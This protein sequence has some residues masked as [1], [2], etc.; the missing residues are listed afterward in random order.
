MP[1]QHIVVLNR[2]VDATSRG[3]AN[4]VEAH[5]NKHTT[6]TKNTITAQ[7]SHLRAAPTRCPRCTSFPP[8]PPTS[9]RY[10]PPT[11]LQKIPNRLLLCISF[12]SS[13]HTSNSIP[14]P[15]PLFIVYSPTLP[16]T[17]LP[18]TS[19]PYTSLHYNT[20]Y[21]ILLTTYCYY[22]LLLLTYS[23]Y[24]ILLATTCCYVLLL[25]IT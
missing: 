8:T 13:P 17:T 9:S 1:D 16:Y 6:P 21:L 25:T 15:P 18:Y 12:S 5:H 3:F 20:S 19:V 22:L 4:C 7:I 14:P 23:Y 2:G 11:P 24:L 10:D